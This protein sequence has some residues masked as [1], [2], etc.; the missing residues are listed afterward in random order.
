MLN[1]LGGVKLYT[2]PEIDAL[3]KQANGYTIVTKLPSI[4]TA[5]TGLVYYKRTTGQITE[6][7]GYRR[8]TDTDDTDDIKSTEDS[9]YNT[10][11]YSKYP[12]LVPYVV[13]NDPKGHR[14][15]YTTGTKESESSPLSDEE[16]LAIWNKHKNELISISGAD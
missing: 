4:E 1:V 12:V 7:Q 2:V 14:A 8:E 15:W 3:I 13:G 10:P 11:V 9:E 16:I 5:N 6:L